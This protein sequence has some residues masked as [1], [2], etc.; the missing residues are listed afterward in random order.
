MIKKKFLL[1]M[2]F[3]AVIFLTL[4]ISAQYVRSFPAISQSGSYGSGLFNWV[5]R[6]K[7]E[8]VGQDFVVQ[9]TPFGC[10]PAVVRDDLLEEND[11]P[12]FCQL[13]ATK[14]NPLIDVE[15]IDS[16][17]LTGRDV[18]NFVKIVDFQPRRAALSTGQENKL[19]DP[20]LN[21]LGYAVIVLKQQKNSSVFKNCKQSELFGIDMGE[22]CIV[23]GN[24]TATLRYDL[25]N[26]FGIGKASFYLPEMTDQEWR[27]RY[28]QYSFWNG[29]GYLRVQGIDG[30]DQS[31]RAVIY[32]D[33]GI[34]SSI[35]LK[36]GEEPRK[37][38]LP[39][40]ECAAGLEL[41]L[42][43]LADP[44]TRARF[45]INGEIVEV[46]KGETFLENCDIREAPVKQGL[47]ESV[48]VHC[49]TDN[50]KNENFAPA[51]SPK[52]KLRICKDNQGSV[53]CE[54]KE[55][56]VGDFLF[57]EDKTGANK[58][59]YLAFVGTEVNEVSRKKE[60]YAYLVAI[61]DYVGDKVGES[62][63]TAAAEYDKGIRSKSKTGIRFIDGIFE[64][65][66]KVGAVNMNFGRWFVEGENIKLIRETSS[67]VLGRKVLILGLGEGADNILDDQTKDYYNKAIN[68]F[69]KVIS[70]YSDTKYPDN[71]EFSNGEN[72]SLQ[73]IRLAFDLNQKRQGARFCEEFKEKYP[74][75][76]LQIEVNNLCDN[77]Y[78][79]ASSGVLESEVLINGKT[80]RIYFEGVY[81]PSFEEYGVEI[82]VSNIHIPNRQE[83]LRLTKNQNL[84]LDS[85]FNDPHSSGNYIQ[86]S[87]IGDDLQEAKFSFPPSIRTLKKGLTETVGNYTFTILDLNL[88]KVARI[89][90]DAGIDRQT[91][92]V[93]FPFKIGVEKRGIK[94][95]PDETKEK[96]EELNKSVVEWERKSNSLG[97]LTQS[98]KTACLGV[99]L[100][101]MAKN[102]LANVGGKGIARQEVM[103]GNGGWYQ[104]CQGKVNNKEFS[105][106]DRC[107]SNY[108]SEIN[109]DVDIRY[110][111]LQEQNRRIKEVED[112]CKKNGLLGE[113]VIDDSCF[114]TRYL[115]LYGDDIEESLKSR[116]PNGMT[117]DGRQISVDDFMRRL[118][119][120]SVSFEEIRELELNSGLSGTQT[121]SDMTKKRIDILVNGVYV[122]T[123]AGVQRS[124]F[125]TESSSDVLNPKADIYAGAETL[126]GIYRGSTA[127]KGNKYG[128]PEG[129]PVQLVIHN[130]KEYAVELKE[131]AYNEYTIENIYNSSGHKIAEDSTASIGIK[132]IVNSFK[133]FDS[134]SYDGNLY[135]SS[136]G[137]SEPVLRFYEVEPFKGLPALVPFDKENGWYASI[138]QRS[139]GVLRA[140]DDSA[141]VNSFYL[142]NV[143]KD[144]IEQ[145]RQGD[146]ECRMINM[147][148]GMP[149]EEFY[150]L[151]RDQTR[152]LVNKAVRAIAEASEAR[153]RNPSAKRISISGFGSVRVGTPAIDLPDIQCQDIMS[154][155]ECKIMFNVCDPVICPSSRC[156]LGGAYPVKDV[157]QSG[158]VGSLV[159]CLPNFPE[160]YV[161]VCL[162]GL[163][164][165]IDSWISVQKSTMDCLQTS[166]D[167]GDTV[168]ICDEINS[169]YQCEFFWREA[170]PFTKLA[171][172]KI[173]EVITGQNVRGG[174]EY[175]GVKDAWSNAESSVNYFTQYYGANSYKA[176]KARSLDEF[177]G[178]ICK[179]YVSGVFPSGGDIIDTL[180]QP[181]SP[182]QFTGRFDEIPYTTTTNP[183]AS[184]YKVFYHIYAGNDR[185]AYFRVY[186]KG[187]EESSY[188]QD[189]SSIRNVDSGYIAKGAYKTETKDFLAPSGYKQLCIMVNEQ[190]ECGFQQVSTDFA[191]NYIS[192]KYAAQ[193]ASQSDIRTSEECV[194]GKTSLYTLIN[195][196][197]QEGIYD[198]LNPNAYNYNI[199][200][201]CATSNP[202]KGTDEKWNIPNESRWKDVG[203]CDDSRMRCWLDTHSVRDAIKNLNIENEVLSDVNQQVQNALNEQGYYVDDFMGEVAKISSGSNTGKDRIRL[204]TQLLDKTFLTAQKA[205]L[206]L[207]RG[208]EYATLTKE[209]FINEVS[210]CSDGTI[211]SFVEINEFNAKQIEA[212]REFISDDTPPLVPL[213]ESSFKFT[214]GANGEMYAREAA[215]PCD[216]YMV[217]NVNGEIQYADPNKGKIQERKQY[218]FSPVFELQDGESA[219]NLM[220]KY[221]PS[222]WVWGS[223]TNKET[224][225]DL[226]DF[227]YKTFFGGGISDK[228]KRFIT[229]FINQN[230]DFGLRKLYERVFANDEGQWYDPRDWF[231]GGAVLKTTHVEMNKDG[232]FKV[233]YD[234]EEM[235]LKFSSIPEKQNPEWWFSY[236]EKNDWRTIIKDEMPDNFKDLFKE[237]SGEEIDF[238]E[239]AKIIFNLDVDEEEVEPVITEVQELPP[240]QKTS[241]D[242]VN[243][244]IFK[245]RISEYSDII[246]RMSQ[247][248]NIPRNLIIA[249][250]AK[251][252]SG[253]KDARGD[254][255][256]SA[257]L[258][259]ISQDAASTVGKGGEYDSKKY[260]PEYNIDV[261]TAY[262][263]WIQSQFTSSNSGE[264]LKKITLT[265]YN[266][267]I[268]KVEDACDNKK[269]ENCRNVAFQALQHVSNILAME[270]ELDKQ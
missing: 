196:N 119:S 121:T 143:M 75:S 152:E 124:T 35:N 265:A 114:E 232:I 93:N 249:I 150:G 267:G 228:N 33:Q 42:D 263:K 15:A 145:N 202:G 254:N 266:W 26:A 231:A 260:D 156:D 257:G 258:M 108:S 112:G 236:Q 164:A 250:I 135:E 120:P 153:E 32:N 248:Y 76:K 125:E 94:L 171:V 191:V 139:S 144:G 111:K 104:I 29:K 18:D 57:Y 60:L 96:I 31:A 17:R 83:T 89:S 54:E 224:W 127:L 70:D 133:K 27:D 2:F 245:N 37:I 51:L 163:K 39:G 180:T 192:D 103:R 1:V 256:N 233:E 142:C 225:F 268:G 128:I 195:P 241:L 73:K 20:I 212:F 216:N 44:D 99:S 137:E 176:F 105:D 244:Q 209:V 22:G 218:E 58:A 55:K 243:S 9:T 255:G 115:E 188:Y 53:D 197:L 47:V 67:D 63:L 72:A 38:Y 45:R 242:T 161:P 185:G 269:W 213:P 136:M 21:N 126:T 230:Y 101:L 91:T 80:Y 100:V 11:V 207:W 149:Y 141:R 175:L 215:N 118:N 206:Y 95:S 85:I 81:E 261:G 194:S 169:F 148:S 199:L 237:L 219:F 193:Q 62:E 172:P 183:P 240:P 66:N 160:V 200:R 49:D 8:D 36:K 147:A 235:Y 220:Y 167:T 227:S 264:N 30:E 198:T 131:S 132:Q 174:G 19:N 5:E 12:V 251:E 43:E 159:L 177:G 50:N 181:D 25:N 65:F 155:G 79:M 69:N 59:V 129:K 6:D 222:G 68:D 151:T 110:R 116:Y 92:E 4:G 221:Q 170:V 34:V 13:G 134:A 52:I 7:C 226:Q 40:F 138:E 217:I 61:P 113:R 16:V 48:K 259:Q 98:M 117:I 201:V 190:V 130:H 205:F 208:V 187:A 186:L 162:S 87:E 247:R 179:S 41:K 246:N 157:V 82:A 204:I 24:I 102:F 106:I 252:S 165:G 166:L 46:S 262:Y 229:G 23:E 239:G 84:Y 71:A 14:I 168:G 270:A 203:Y 109:K 88:K 86:L 90:I 97:N 210:K 3:V 253:N 146:D 238:L 223:T 77:E 74:N 211:L 56:G 78:L 184:Q 140:Y 10:T 173:L 122:N 154:P 28:L 189:T 214:K 234:D 107:L 64:V 158:I 182:S 178:E 123:N